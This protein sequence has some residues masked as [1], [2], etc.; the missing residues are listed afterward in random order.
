MRHVFRYVV[1][2]EPVDGDEIVLAEADSHHLATVVRRRAGDGIEVIAPSGDLWPCEVVDAGPPARVRVT[3]APRQA[4]RVRPVR[5]WVG[6]A[7]GGRLD[8]VAEKAAELGVESLGVM[9]TARAKRVP[10]ERAWGKRAERMARVAEAAARQ[11]GR[12]AWPAPGPL[13]PFD[14]VLTETVPEQGVMLDPR[15]AAPM[16]DI[17]RARP[18]DQPVTVLVGPDTGFDDA[19]VHAAQARGIATAGMGDGMLRTETA[20]IAAAVL[21]T[22]GYDGGGGL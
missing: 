16:A 8:L 12:G 10:D 5:L 11:S 22:M 20:A 18:A 2:D 17:L 15:A 6:L 14:H 1:A 7:E 21:A 19:E 4:P 9:V 13:V 3:G